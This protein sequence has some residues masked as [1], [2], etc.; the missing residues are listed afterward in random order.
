MG[1]SFAVVGQAHDQ[2]WVDEDLAAFAERLATASWGGA[3]YERL[4]IGPV[5][6]GL[7]ECMDASLG[8]WMQPAA[9]QEWRD[10]HAGGRIGA[11]GAKLFVA[12]DGLLTAAVAPLPN[13]LSFLMFACHEMVE[14]ALDRRHETEGHE[15]KEMTHTGLAH[16]LW[17]EYVVERTRR[18]IA[19]ELGWGYA[20]VENGFVVEQM[21][22]IENELP[23]LI[24]WA[25]QHDE[26]PQRI[27]QHWYEMARV[28]SMALGRADAGSPTEQ[29][30]VQRFRQQPLV[31]ESPTGWDALDA[32]LRSAF[33]QPAEQADALDQLVRDDG[34][35]Q[36]YDGMAALWNKRYE[37]ALG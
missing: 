21:R 1:A 12:H 8:E 14:A 33:A 16:V 17:T 37:M 19:T 25:V 11:T 27:F 7:R 30:Q 9:Y 24:S 32:A 35:E 23:Q 6:A 5:G 2:R 34:W 10:G 26:P 28:Y 18:T 31:M 13:R 22:D 15:F 3:G 36:L 20:D 4:V 29:E